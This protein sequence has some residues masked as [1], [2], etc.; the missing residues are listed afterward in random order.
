MN[1]RRTL[2]LFAL[3][4][5]AYALLTLPG[6]FWPGY[7]DT[8]FGLLVVV[9]FLSIYVFH[10]IGIP[11]LLQHGGACGWGWCAPTVLG[12]VVLVGFWLGVAGLLARLVAGRYTDADRG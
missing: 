12:W 6:L 10:G 5:A 1:R 9:P 2:R 4:V 8:P 3:I 11:G 7:L